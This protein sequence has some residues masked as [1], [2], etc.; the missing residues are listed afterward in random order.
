MSERKPLEIDR[1]TSAHVYNVSIQS[2]KCPSYK[3]QWIWNAAHRNISS[4]FENVIDAYTVERFDWI[5]HAN[6]HLCEHR[7]VW[8][9]PFHLAGVCKSI[10]LIRYK[11]LK[12]FRK[13]ARMLQFEMYIHTELFIISNGS[14]QFNQLNYY[15]TTEH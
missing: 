4:T 15:R 3:I 10:S 14:I 5:N 8:C 11:L 1:I 9:A 12:P 6:M 2:I 7:I 13:T